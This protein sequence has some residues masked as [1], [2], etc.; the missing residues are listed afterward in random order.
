MLIIRGQWTL[1]EF[2]Y[3]ELSKYLK[4]SS[5]DPLGRKIIECC[6]NDGSLDDYEKP[7]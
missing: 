4:E 7:V 2:F 6:L 3:K 5:L 1:K